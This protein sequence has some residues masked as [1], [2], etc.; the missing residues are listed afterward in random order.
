[1][2]GR[3]AK[4]FEVIWIA[5]ASLLAG[6]QTRIG[7]QADVSVRKVIMWMRIAIVK[8]TNWL[9]LKW[10]NRPQGFEKI[11]MWMLA[12]VVFGSAVSG[13]YWLKGAEHVFMPLV[14]YTNAHPITHQVLIV[15]AFV[16]LFAFQGT[17][18]KALA[19]HSGRIFWKRAF[20]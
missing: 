19:W 13:F 4:L 20:G 1:V 5:Y 11:P 12:F 14:D 15:C 10:K 3:N 8:L 17:F 18:F 6:D 16:G 9:S 7:I 2:Q